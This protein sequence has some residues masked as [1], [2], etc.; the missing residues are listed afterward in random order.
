MAHP[1][2]RWLV[3]V[4]FC[5][6]W[7]CLDAFQPVAPVAPGRGGGR[8][9]SKDGLRRAG[10]SRISHPR[11]T[12]SVFMSSTADTR[13]ELILQEVKNWEGVNVDIKLE[14]LGGNRRRIS[15][16][17][18]IEAPPR[19]IW[20]TLTNYNELHRYIPN[21]AESGAQLQPNGRVRIEQVGVISATLNLK[22]RIVL[23][24][25]EKPYSTL[26]FNKVESREFIEF[27]G[28]YS[29]SEP[30]QTGAS[31]L[32]YSV[33]ALPH[34]LLPVQLV[35][36]KIRA[37]VPPMLAAVRTNANKYQSMRVQ[38]LGPDWA[39][40]VPPP[41]SG[42]YRRRIQTM[43][44]P[45][46]YPDPSPT[47]KKK[48]LVERVSGEFCLVEDAPPKRS[49]TRSSNMDVE[50]ETVILEGPSLPFSWVLSGILQGVVS[51]VKLFPSSGNGNGTRLYYKRKNQ[52]KK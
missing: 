25:D 23:E 14:G 15:G 27:R 4:C 33:E 9:A 24:V 50:G 17:L 3:F 41:L 37:E 38:A 19:A 44:K 8:F 43:K 11:R 5:S 16:G 35:Q 47:R 20:D 42:V 10:A 12:A 49:G 6:S 36:S 13:A 21:I 46:D 28:T 22:T 34:P 1:C 7:L 48:K 45:V 2:V 18:F 32:E 51:L 26:T 29:I 31:Y 40:E 30:D 39:T 52:R